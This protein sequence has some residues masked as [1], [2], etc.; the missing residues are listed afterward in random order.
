MDMLL[1]KQE[2]TDHFFFSLKSYL[3]TTF[4]RIMLK[5]LS[6]HSEFRICKKS[7]GDSSKI[8]IKE[9][10]VQNEPFFFKLGWGK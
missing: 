5:I 3:E 6:F 9:T 2:E 10:K 4:L 8:T 1:E 7:S